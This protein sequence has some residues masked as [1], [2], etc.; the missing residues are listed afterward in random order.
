MKLRTYSAILPLAM[1]A[2]VLAQA[3]APKALPAGGSTRDLVLNV[4]KSLVLESP[5]D[6]LRVSVASGEILEVVA[7]SPREVVINGKGVGESSLILWQASGNRLMFDVSVHKPD[8]KLEALR[9]ELVKELG[10]QGVSASLEGEAV[11]LRGT[12]KD[13]LSAER[14]VA[15]AEPFGKTV[16]L[17]PSAV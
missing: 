10:E 16:N 7:V 3:P 11:F 13:L 9:R 8:L 1:A 5:E 14:A 4:G 12:V 17:L 2:V 15:I 6:I